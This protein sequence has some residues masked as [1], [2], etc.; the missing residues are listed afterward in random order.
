MEEG[1]RL[2]RPGM[3]AS[4]QQRP[5]S[6]DRSA[7]EVGRIGDGWLPTAPPGGGEENR[8]WPAPYER[9]WL[10]TVEAGGT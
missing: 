6:V 10:T 2:G 8:R 5:S 1:L 3:A 9:R 4:G 7:A